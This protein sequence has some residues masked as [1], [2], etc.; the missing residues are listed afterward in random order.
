LKISTG[1][2]WLSA[3]AIIC[4]IP[5]N[6]GNAAAQVSNAPLEAPPD[7][8][9]RS[10]RD[11][12]TVIA[13]HNTTS[14]KEGDWKRVEGGELPAYDPPAGISWNY[15][16]GVTLYGMSRTAEVTGQKQIGDFVVKH[17][18]IVAKQYDYLA[19]Q[20]KT[21]GKMGP[22]AGLDQIVRLS[23]LDN[24]G[25]MSSALAE[26]LVKHGVEPI[27][28]I[29]NL[30]KIVADYITNKQSRLEDGTLCRKPREDETYD[31]VTIW[32]DDLYMSCP[33][34]ARWGTYSK[35]AR[36][37]DD[38]A[39]QIISFASRLQDKD[40]LWY[41]GYMIGQGKHSPGKWGRGNGWAMVATVEVLSQIP[42]NHKDRAKLLDILR[43]H[44][45][46]V[47]RVQATS[48]MWRQALDRPDFW[49]E[50]SCTA[51]F[52]YG[53]ARAVNR[54]WISKGNLKYAKKAFAAL[55]TRVGWDGVVIGTCVGTGIGNDLNYYY[56]RK[57]TVDD[58]HGIG[59]ILLAG[60][61]LIAAGEK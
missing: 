39:H 30:L 14:L 9:D 22:L 13:L 19:W 51:M 3:I 45:V 54:G 52:S 50:T 24:C 26:G 21:Y 18:D 55:K 36:Y 27:P 57:T 6:Q 31:R 20:K 56:I 17:N 42:E 11:V 37:W 38:A 15:P 28:E 7:L 23:S 35:N 33:F 61:E 46:G 60:S 47:K 4:S 43:R 1:L 32:V 29:T 12:I 34:L 41:H 16:W 2:I 53:I 40:G 58:S 10:I 44:I 5:T 48:G 25:S 8:R 49:E 59:P